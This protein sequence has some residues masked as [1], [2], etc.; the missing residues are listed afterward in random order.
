MG[1]SEAEHR[2]WRIL[3]VED[4]VDGRAV[5]IDT[6]ELHGIACDAA[7]TA[8]EG[9]ALLEAHH[10]DAAIID[11]SLP[12]MDGMAFLKHIR[13]QARLAQLPCI[14]FTAY[15]SSKVRQDVLNAGFNAYFE[16]PLRQAVLVQA[17]EEIIPT[18]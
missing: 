1:A 15:H 8:E 14:A 17:L 11:L 9:I 4:E 16:K 18:G 2:A 3:V 12:G 10:Y 5:M 7:A 13:G 6:L